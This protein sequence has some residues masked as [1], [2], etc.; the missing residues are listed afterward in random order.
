MKIKHILSFVL[1][2]TLT[3]LFVMRV[4]AENVRDCAEFSGRGA[5]LVPA[6]GAC[7]HF[8]IETMAATEKEAKEKNNTVTEAIRRA[9]PTKEGRI[10]LNEEGFYTWYNAEADQYTVSRSL[11]LST[12]APD[13][14]RA[15]ADKLVELG[16]TSI[17][18][19]S[20]TLSD[21]TPYRDRLID[22]ALADA[23][24]KLSSL[25]GHYLLSSVHEFGLYAY[26]SNDNCT[27]RPMVSVTCDLT[28]T[29]VPN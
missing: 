16:A 13:R 1:L 2:L 26:D 3:C 10:A 23:R 21:T 25:E 12:S 27:T 19:I 24:A 6:D 20:Y 7:I 14:T 9:Y 8:T 11:A 5:L 22:L 4:G 17:G 28:A 15:I 29:F 18:Y